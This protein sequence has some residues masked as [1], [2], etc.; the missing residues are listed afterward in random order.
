MHDSLVLV[1]MLVILPSSSSSSFSSS[2][3]NRRFRSLDSL[4]IDAC[5]DDDIIPYKID[6]HNG[7]DEP[8]CSFGIQNDDRHNALHVTYRPKAAVTFVNVAVLW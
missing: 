4:D 1:C 5:D 2:T 8:P 6:I 3:L 7:A